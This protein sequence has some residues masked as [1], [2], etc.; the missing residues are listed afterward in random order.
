MD[1]NLSDQPLTDNGYHS[2]GIRETR[3][4]NVRLSHVLYGYHD[5]NPIFAPENV[6]AAM[7]ADE[8]SSYAGWIPDSFVAITGDTES[9]I[10]S[11]TGNIAVKSPSPLLSPSARTIN[12]TNLI[13]GYINYSSPTVQQ[14]TSLT[15]GQEPR[16]DTSSMQNDGS[17][18]ATSE[19]TQGGE[20]SSV[21]IPA[22]SNNR[23]ATP[24][25]NQEEELTVILA[26]SAMA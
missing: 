6:P 13:H 11:G 24:Q 9:A 19:D 15:N 23:P 3:R 21:Q 2:T 18:C 7:K 12:L 25:K 5:Y 1:F 16:M 10:A 14:V 20:A 8:G 4:R 26:T 22:S 17:S